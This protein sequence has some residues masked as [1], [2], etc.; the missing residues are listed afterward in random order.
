[1]LGEVRMQFGAND[2]DFLIGMDQGF[3]VTGALAENGAREQ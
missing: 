2:A 3:A 1:M